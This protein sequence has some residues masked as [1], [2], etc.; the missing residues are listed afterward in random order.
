MKLCPMLPSVYVVIKK[1]FTW[2]R[3][4]GVTSTDWRSVTPWR[5]FSV[6][7]DAVRAP[8]PGQPDLDRA[9]R[10]DV[11]SHDHREPGLEPPDADG[12]DRGRARVPGGHRQRQDR[13]GRATA[14]WSGQLIFIIKLLLWDRWPWW[15]DFK[16]TVMITRQMYLTQNLI[17]RGVF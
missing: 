7:R 6:Q 11:A 4:F 3:I 9:R 17:Y 5:L 1:Q 16:F 2:S 8:Q 15:P 13:T 12:R 14:R 10:R